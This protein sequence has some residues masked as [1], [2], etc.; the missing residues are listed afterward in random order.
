MGF[1]LLVNQTYLRTMTRLFHRLVRHIKNPESL[2]GFRIFVSFK[3]QSIILV[4]ACRSE[5]LHL[6]RFF[7]QRLVLRRLF[8][9]A[10]T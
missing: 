4:S 3:D 10:T 2:V 7:F 1:L 8:V 5:V 6:R 9:P